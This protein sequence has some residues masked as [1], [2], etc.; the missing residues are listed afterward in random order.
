MLE[1][2]TL[3]KPDIDQ[4][5][6]LFEE[7]QR[8]YQVP[9]PP[10]SEIVGKLVQLPPGAE[11]LVA[12]IPAIIGFAA[13]STIYP[14]PGLKSGFFLKE[15]FVAPSQRGTGTGRALM[16]AVA[17]LAIARGHS[18]VDWTADRG[19]ARLLDFYSGLGAVAQEEKVFYRL[20]AEALALCAAPTDG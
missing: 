12:T 5:A 20:S 14:G 9:V 18:R 2:R 3:A 11:I 13:F 15:L 8:H 4:L 7:M 10:R 19:N 17:R 16:T 6:T 1:I